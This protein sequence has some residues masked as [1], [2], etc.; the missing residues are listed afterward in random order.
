MLASTAPSTCGASCHLI[1]RDAHGPRDVEIRYWWAAGNAM[2]C[3]VHILTVVCKML[4]PVV[5]SGH[6]PKHASLY[7]TNMYLP[8]ALFLTAPQSPADTPS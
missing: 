7:L 4:S 1:S 2:A 8:H 3:H 5:P 6:G